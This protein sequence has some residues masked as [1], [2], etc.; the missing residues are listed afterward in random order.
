MTMQKDLSKI[1]KSFSDRRVSVNHAIRS[2]RRNG[3]RV[4]EDQAII[5]LDFLYLVASSFKKTDE[6]GRIK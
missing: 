4:S 2:L 6:I 1:A 3:I 5:I